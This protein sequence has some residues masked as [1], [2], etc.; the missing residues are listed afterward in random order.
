MSA[1]DLKIEIQKALDHVPEYILQDMLN[2]IKQLNS[3][4]Q[5]N[6]E[7]SKNLKK[8]LVEDSDLLKK[9]AQ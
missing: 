2:Y 9:L 5:E 1:S 3:T 7:F 4:T 8:I 6:I